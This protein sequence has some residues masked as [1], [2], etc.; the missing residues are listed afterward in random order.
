MVNL[1]RQ[2]LFLTFLLA[3]TDYHLSMLTRE[4][5]YTICNKNPLYVSSNYWGYININYNKLEENGKCTLTLMACE[6]CVISLFLHG[7]DV[8]GLCASKITCP[9]HLSSFSTDVYSGEH[10]CYK[11]RCPLIKFIATPANHMVLVPSYQ[12]NCQISTKSS[13]IHIDV[14]QSQSNVTGVKM[15]YKVDYETTG[16][17]RQHWFQREEFLNFTMCM[18]YG[19]SIL[20]LGTQGFIHLSN[21]SGKCVLVLNS[22]R[23]C[24]IH[25]YMDISNLTGNNQLRCLTIKISDKFKRGE[26]IRFSALQSN[27]LNYT[28]F[29]KA[30]TFEICQSNIEGLQLKIF[31]KVIEKLETK[32]ASATNITL[33]QLPSNYPPSDEIFKYYVKK[34]TTSGHLQLIFTNYL[35]CADCYVVIAFGSSVFNNS[36]KIMRRVYTSKDTITMKYFTGKIYP[37]YCG[38]KAEI[39]YFEDFNIITPNANCGKYQ[40]V[41]T[42]GHFYFHTIYDIYYDCIWVLVSEPRQSFFRQ[43]YFSL[44][45][46]ASLPKGSHV[47]IH[48]GNTSE[49]Q[50]LDPLKNSKNYYHPNLSAAYIRLQGLVRNQD[51]LDILFTVKRN[52]C[53]L[54]T[55]RCVNGDCIPKYMRCNSQIDCSDYSDENGCSLFEDSRKSYSSY[56][57]YSLIIIIVVTTF[58]ILSLCLFF[59]FVCK[60]RRIRLTSRRNS[61]ALSSVGATHNHIRMNLTFEGEL[62][63]PPTYDE[64]MTPSSLQGNFNLAFNWSH[65][66]INETSVMPPT[67]QEYMQQISAID[68]VN[69]RGDN[70]EAS[71]DNTVQQ[72]LPEE[73]EGRL[74]RESSNGNKDQT[75]PAA[76]T[77][78]INSVENSLEISQ[79][80]FDINSNSSSC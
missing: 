68:C 76:L 27:Y 65:S 56:W 39:R 20:H 42:S 49:G 32:F 53:A 64:V 24:K 75:V 77:I 62:D 44:S 43:I 4:R 52:Q 41:T 34:F 40:L 22:C 2:N 29:S 57:S 9:C 10:Y 46:N 18:H 16:L 55:F 8:N 60:I 21:C 36:Q 70:D 51:K 69:S 47:D 38:L 54:N 25:F 63:A 80:V 59:I 17:I 31:Y 58:I 73:Q 15:T 72:T 67:Y 11:R 3:I 79:S 23:K 28:T 48:C 6:R 19:D 7:E 37:G 26:Y 71:S 30:A 13:E 5:D 50:K 66:N 33:L 35:C 12:T 1:C 78:D 14:C 74:Q 45:V 61:F